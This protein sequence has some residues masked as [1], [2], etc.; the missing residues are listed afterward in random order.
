MR[1]DEDWSDAELVQ[2]YLNGD[3][4][5]W[6][7][8]YKRYGYKLKGYF[9]NNGVNFADAEDLA[10]DMLIEAIVKLSNLRNPAAFRGWLFRIAQ[11]L[12]AKWFY[13]E[14]RHPPHES[15]EGGTYKD[16]I[17]EPGAAYFVAA[18]VHR[19]PEERAISKEE[20]S[21]VLGLIARLPKSQR[22]VLQLKASDP[23]MKMEEI[24]DALGIKLNTVKLRLHRGRKTLAKWLE[25]K[26]PG[27]FTRWISKWV[28]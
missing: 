1:F 11:G 15:L 8:I 3:E 23:D 4:S 27:D 16:G 6:D 28:D 24:A 18:P 13:E 21:I 19:Q 26:Y 7:V 2:D 9:I 22:E 25:A 20:E 10:Q 14:S 5:A 12:M 17:S